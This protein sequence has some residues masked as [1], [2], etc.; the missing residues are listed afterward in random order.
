[1]GRV[2][3]RAGGGKVTVEGLSPAVVQQGK[4]VTIKQGSKVVQRVAGTFTGPSTAASVAQIN[5]ESEGT[6]SCPLNVPAGTFKAFLT[7][8]W[9]SWD[10]D[11][12]ASGSSASFWMTFN[13]A[14]VGSGATITGPGTLVGYVNVVTN[15]HNVRASCSI[16]YG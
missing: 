4:T 16:F 1:M 9:C 5:R 6:G 14:S 13:G 10:K 11:G 2:L 3:M 7:G 8:Y 15:Y 12:P